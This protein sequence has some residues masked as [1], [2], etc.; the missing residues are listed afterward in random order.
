[1]GGCSRYSSPSFEI[2]ADAELHNRVDLL[3]R[4]ASDAVSSSSP[5]SVLILAAYEKWGERCPEFLLGE[6]AFAIW[7]HPR[8][9]LF[10]ARDH[11]GWRPLFYWFDGTRLA[12]SSDQLL[13]FSVPGVCR[14]LN[15]TKLGAFGAARYRNDGHPH[16]TFFRGVFSLPPAAALTFTHDGPSLRSY[17]DPEDI[18][19]QIPPR[20]EDA[21]EALRELLF[22][23]VSC[24]LRSKERVAVFLSGG[25]DSSALT[26]LAAKCL[27]KSNRS[28]NAIAAVLPESSKPRFIDEREFIEEFRQYPNVDIEYVAP[29]TGGPFDWI[30]HASCFAA[31]PV[32]QPAAYLLD[33]M[34]GAAVD[35]H[36][37]V[38]LW[39]AGGEAGPTAHAWDYYLELAFGFRWPTLA[40]ELYRFRALSG[41]SPVRLLGG[42]MRNLLNPGT[43]ISRQMFLFAPDFLRQT[44]DVPSPVLLWPN[45]RR[46]Q[47]RF[48]TAI[49]SVHAFPYRITASRAPVT[50][51][52]L[53]KRVLEF[54]L[55]APGNLKVRNG[56]PRYLIRG[57][58]NG[59]LPQR[60]QWRTDKRLFAPDYPKRFRAQQGKAADFVSSIGRRDP[61]RQIVDVD[62]LR[63]MLGTE[64]AH[65]W[66]KSF[67]VV[68]FTIY[69]ICFLRQFVEFQP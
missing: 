42:L 35:R 47:Q 9:R 37:E 45:H 63:S 44:E 4:L 67:G 46:A 15:R 38:V 66:G 50:F 24:R 6:F 13:L 34:H 39:G 23:A 1:M 28:L 3:N 61:V 22:E 49:R 18:H 10:C 43:A 25:L 30:E 40:R 26:V 65:D 27:A 41:R 29:E 17:W 19:V 20:P 31:G 11:M 51:P 69:L 48:V 54:C 52:F 2:I 36:A 55:A 58:L 16:E 64:I 57:A 21:F 12:F 59:M 8:Q 68:P 60:I 14:E 5:D 33:A 32:I 7:D 56:Y 62:R 53:D